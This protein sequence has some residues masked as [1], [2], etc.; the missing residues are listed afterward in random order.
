MEVTIVYYHVFHDIDPV[1][2]PQ[3]M[4]FTLAVDNN[5]TLKDIFEATGQE[6]ADVSEYYYLSRPFSFNLRCVPF[7][8]NSKGQIDWNVYFDNVKVVD[9]I[10]THHLDNIIESKIG[11]PQAGGPGF[12]DYYTVWQSVYPII[13]QFVTVIGLGAIVVNAGKWVHSLFNKNGKNEIPPQSAYD[14]VFLRKKWNHFD[15]GELLNINSDEAKTLLKTCGYTY[16]PKIQMFV[17]QSISLELRE[18]LSNVNV[19][20]K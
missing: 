19:Y 18:N 4:S 6:F 8:I 10:S 15:L 3:S 16:D 13:D 9:F 17:L 14:V 12:L 20:D 11:Y 2:F 5:T 1:N 7:I